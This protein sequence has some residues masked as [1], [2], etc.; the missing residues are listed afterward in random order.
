MANTAQSRKR[1]R[2][3]ENRR[4]HNV[5]LRTR[6]RSAIKK[7]QAAISGGDKTAAEAEYKSACAIIDKTRAKGLIHQNKAAR[8]KSRLSAQVRAL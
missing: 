4:Q 3:A 5:P 6:F 7:V 8:H 2:Q 1:A